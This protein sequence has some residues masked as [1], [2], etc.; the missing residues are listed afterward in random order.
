[1][2]VPFISLLSSVILGE[3]SMSGLKKI[4]MFLPKLITLTF[5]LISL[6]VFFIGKMNLDLII[7]Y[8]MLLEGF[9]FS[10][11]GG[12]GLRAIQFY[13]LIDGWLDGNVV[14]GAGNGSNTNVIRDVDM[15]W[16]YELTYV[17]LLFST[18][19]IGVVV[20]FSWF[21]WGLLR[22]RIA[23]KGNDVAKLYVSPIVTGVICLALAAASNPYFG[24]FDYLW[25]IMLPHL[26]A[27]GIKYQRI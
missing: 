12:G 19:L 7:V 13:S 21:F 3:F 22:L 14:F 25:I 6:F 1:M 27:A 4:N 16:A 17:Y 9:D 18:G 23:L 26:I 2:S 10:Q 5:L 24:K 20:Y 8:E 11:T 15:P